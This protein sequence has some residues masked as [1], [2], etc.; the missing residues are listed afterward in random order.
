MQSFLRIP[1]WAGSASLQ[2]S[3]CW[4]IVCRYADKQTPGTG[5]WQDRK[6][7]HHGT[8]ILDTT[9]C[10]NDLL[11]LL[12]ASKTTPPAESSMTPPSNCIIQDLIRRAP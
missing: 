6:A 8:T 7:P 3:R 2:D 4:P 11:A 10:R 9:E 12:N 5:A 1:E